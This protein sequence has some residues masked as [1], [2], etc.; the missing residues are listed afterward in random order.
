MQE[1][2]SRSRNII[3]LV[4]TVS[5]EIGDKLKNSDDNN[6]DQVTSISYKIYTH[7]CIVYYRYI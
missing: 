5:R 7:T 3:C 2:N 1:D 6:D 4:Y